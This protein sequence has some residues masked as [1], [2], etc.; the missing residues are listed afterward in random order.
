MPLRRYVKP[1]KSHKPEPGAGKVLNCTGNFFRKE[2][3]RTI[4]TVSKNANTVI[5]RIKEVYSK[6]QSCILIISHIFLYIFFHVILQRTT[7]FFFLNKEMDEEITPQRRSTYPEC[8]IFWGLSIRTA[9]LI[10]RSW[11]GQ[12]LETVILCHSDCLG[13][14]GVGWRI[15]CRE[16]RQPS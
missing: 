5:I 10:L 1:V 8:F 4:L 2:K 3:E 6:Y 16:K 15:T 13:L 9:S 7:F 14:L 11:S 12:F